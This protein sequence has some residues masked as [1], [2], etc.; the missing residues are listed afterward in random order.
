MSYSEALKILFNE[1][2][3]DYINESFETFEFFEF[4]VSCGGDA[5]V[6]R[7]YKSS[8]KVYER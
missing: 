4:N 6:Y 2:P 5:A 7:I 3:A 8:G 1:T